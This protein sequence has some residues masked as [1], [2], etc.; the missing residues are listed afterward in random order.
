[1]LRDSIYNFIK[2]LYRES[3]NMN[4]LKIFILSILSI[5][6]FYLIN[7]SIAAYSQELQDAYN[8]AYQ[9]KITTINSIDKADM[10]WWLTRIAM[11]KMLSQYAINIL[12]KS[13]DTS[14]IPNFWDIDSKLDED[15]N[16]GVTLAYQLWIMWI[17]IDKF[18]PFDLVTR[19]EFGTALSRVLY[20]TKNEWW[21][22][23]YINH[24]KALQNS[25][26]MTQINQPNQLEIRWYVMLMLMRSDWDKS[27]PDNTLLTWKEIIDIW[28]YFSWLEKSIS[29]VNFA[30]IWT[31][32]FFGLKSWNKIDNS[33][34]L[35]TK[36]PKI[37]SLTFKLWWTFDLKKIDHF[38]VWDT[39]RGTAGGPWFLNSDWTVVINFNEWW[40]LWTMDHILHLDIILKETDEELPK[41]Q[42]LTVK[43][44]NIESDSNIDWSYYDWNPMELLITYPGVSKD[45]HD[46]LLSINPNVK[47]DDYTYSKDTSYEIMDIDFKRKDETA[48]VDLRWLT[49]KFNS[50]I[51]LR[52]Y[53]KSASLKINWNT[54]PTIEDI[55]KNYIKLDAYCSDNK[56]IITDNLNNGNISVSIQLDDL[57]I[58]NHFKSNFYIEPYIVEWD[59]YLAIDLEN[60]KY[61]EKSRNNIWEEYADKNRKTFIFWWEN[62]DGDINGNNEDSNSSNDNSLWNDDGSNND[63]NST[64]NSNDFLS[65]SDNCTDIEIDNWNSY[66]FCIEK[67]DGT[68]YRMSVNNTEN[69][70]MCTIGKGG[71]TW[72]FSNCL[73]EFTVLWAQW[74]SNL[75]LTIK[76]NNKS[77]NKTASYDFDNWVF[78]NN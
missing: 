48:K 41:E 14:K 8:F 12:W 56:T 38:S 16:N 20:W 9:N 40:N 31:F 51:S 71:Q 58:K 24:L 15:Y 7:I 13:P 53:V 1:M 3:I 33:R 78:V 29:I 64:G 30:R 36:N 77:Y 47:N 32:T 76:Y 70:N 34:Y 75:W 61:Y 6:N 60:Y 67:L 39:S 52:N 49:L 21:N 57:R 73:W 23:Y 27:I 11:A 44:T 55:G 28:F 63:G 35:F 72:N 37:Y 19:A 22:P 18:R 59:I 68:S 2:F 74:Q 62:F 65:N 54:C 66:Y 69:L 45:A 42:T 46:Y 10:E 5:I 43:L 17:W 50:D 26:I 4:Y 25:W